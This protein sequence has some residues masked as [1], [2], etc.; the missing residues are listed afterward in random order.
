[1]TG[2]AEGADGVTRRAWLARAF[3]SATVAASALLAAPIVGYVL[4]PLWRRRSPASVQIGRLEDF[5]LDTPRRVDFAS[6]R[7]DG[8][9]TAEG[10]QAVWVVR[11]ANGIRAFD[12]RCTHLACAYH[13]HAEGG[14]FLCPCHNGLYDLDGRVVGGPPPRPLDVYAVTV[15]SGTVY[16]VPLPERRK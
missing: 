11:R 5:P 4:A 6:R 7:R 10:R 1:M 12:P 2:A 3:W 14:Q 15:D 8:W 16:V 13:W 9:V